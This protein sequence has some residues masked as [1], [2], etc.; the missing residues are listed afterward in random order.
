MKV[1]EGVLDRSLRV[2]T[3]VVLIVLSVLGVIGPWGYIGV[4]PLVTGA[5]GLCPLYSMLGISTCPAPRA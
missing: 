1:N 4:I 3:G 5:V 2:A